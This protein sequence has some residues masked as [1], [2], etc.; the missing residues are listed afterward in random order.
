MDNKEVIILYKEVGKKPELRKTENKIEVFENL[1]GGKIEEITYED[2]VIIARKDRKNLQPNIYVAGK[3]LDIGSSIRG[4]VVIVNK[5]SN[6][7][8]KLSKEQAVKYAIFLER[9][10]F[11]CENL[12]GYSPTSREKKLNIEFQPKSINGNILRSAIPSD[13][14]IARADVDDVLKMIVD[15]QRTILKFI[16]KLVN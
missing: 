10:S 14:K 11:N 1:V 4:T 9:A 7:F 6:S 5:D 12:D 15:M 16:Y 8:I 2:I 13:E 3:F